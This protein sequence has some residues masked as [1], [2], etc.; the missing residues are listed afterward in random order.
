MKGFNKAFETKKER[1]RPIFKVLNIEIVFLTGLDTIQ[2]D[3]LTGI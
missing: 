1:E 2:F 3:A